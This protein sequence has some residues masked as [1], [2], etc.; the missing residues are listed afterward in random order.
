LA[1]FLLYSAHRSTSI[2]QQNVTL[3]IGRVDEEATYDSGRS[4]SKGMDGD[5]NEVGSGGRV[6]VV[7]ATS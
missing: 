6:D 3:A 5:V 4:L 1:V 2:L 7:V